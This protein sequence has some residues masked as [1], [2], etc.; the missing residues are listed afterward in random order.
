MSLRALSHLRYKIV[1]AFLSSAVLLLL[2][3]DG[4]S[5]RDTASD[6]AD[7]T[8]TGSVA[9]LLTDAPTD[10]FDRVDVT[11][12]RIELLGDDS[13]NAVLFEGERT[14]DLLALRDNA[15]LFS[16]ADVPAGEYEKIRLTVTQVALVRLDDQGNVIETITPRLPGNGRIDLDPRE[17]FHVQEGQTLMLEIDIDAA[18]SIQ[19]AQAGNEEYLFRPVVFVRVL[20]G[21]TS[22]IPAGEVVTGKLIRIRGEV[23]KIDREGQ[24]FLL[25]RLHL[26]E[27]DKVDLDELDAESDHHPDW[28]LSNTNSEHV[29]KRRGTMNADGTDSDFNLLRHRDEDDHDEGDE[30]GDDSRDEDRNGDIHHPAH[31]DE[32]HPVYR[33][34][35]TVYAGED[36]VLFSPGGSI[37]FDDLSVGDRATVLGRLSI[38]VLQE[39][40]LSTDELL[41]EYYREYFKIKALAILTGSL[42]NYTGARGTATTAYDPETGGL[43]LLVAASTDLEPDTEVPVQLGEESRLFDRRGEPVAPE[44]IVPGTRLHLLGRTE[45]TGDGG[46]LLQAFIGFVQYD[47]TVTEPLT[48]IIGS[49]ETGVSG[50]ILVTANGD[51]CVDLDEDMGVYLI[52]N[53]DGGFISEQITRFELQEGQ[54]VD[55]YGHESSDGCLEA[56]TILARPLPETPPVAGPGA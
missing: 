35:V 4:G 25:C 28:V 34:C 39:M 21:S 30:D 22:E 13:G 1:V 31:P 8:A 15:D 56:E 45:Q 7:A 11:L 2:G 19:V 42:G 52:T 51:Y 18:R 54:E 5:D 20:G 36:T 23:A 55:V 27:L 48:G 12:T 44:T 24:R 14:L 37:G 32:H 49:F 26:H 6:G 16:L 47:S 9:I 43:D 53:T 50:F 38:R 46:M 17:S 40:D 41:D 10:A 29:E 33:A 3:C